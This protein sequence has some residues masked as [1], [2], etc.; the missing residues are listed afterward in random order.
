M[1][2]LTSVNVDWLYGY[3][4]PRTTEALDWLRARQRDGYMIFVKGQ[5]YAVLLGNSPLYN[6]EMR[7]TAEFRFVDARLATLFKLTFA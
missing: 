7:Y 4:M 5:V 3:G 1:T 2:C 6:I